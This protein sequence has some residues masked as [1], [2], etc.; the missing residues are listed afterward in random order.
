MV[1]KLYN[2]LAGGVVGGRIKERDQVRTERS[3]GVQA[4][5]QRGNQQKI[6]WSGLRTLTNTTSG[7]NGSRKGG[8]QVRLIARTQNI[9]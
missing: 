3:G 5:H 1:I 8:Y 2:V 7:E 4:I 9:K 6:S